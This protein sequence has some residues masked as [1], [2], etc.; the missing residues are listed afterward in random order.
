MSPSLVPTGS[1]NL[2]P[3]A[4]P[5]EPPPTA[6]PTPSPSSHSTLP[7]PSASNCV[8]SAITSSPSSPSSVFFCITYV[9]SGTLI[10]TVD[11]VPPVESAG[12]TILVAGVE[13]AIAE[14]LAVELPDVAVEVSCVDNLPI[15]SG[16]CRPPPPLRSLRSLRSLS[17]S[18]I[19][20][21]S[22]TATTTDTSGTLLTLVVAL[23]DAAIN[24]GGDVNADAVLEE[25]LERHR[26]ELVAA[27]EIT[28]EEA[29]EADGTV[30]VISVDVSEPEVVS[31][32]TAS[33]SPDPDTVH[34]NNGGSSN[35]GSSA[36][37][38]EAGV[39]D[40]EDDKEKRGERSGNNSWWMPWVMAAT[41]FLLGALVMRCWVFFTSWRGNRKGPQFATRSATTPRRLRRLS[42]FNFK[43]SPFQNKRPLAGRYASLPT[44]S[45]HKGEKGTEIT[46]SSSTA[47]NGA[48]AAATPRL[49]GLEDIAN[50]TD[51]QPNPAAFPRLLELRDITSGA[52]RVGKPN[53]AA[54]PRLL[55][56]KDL[57][58]DTAV[59]DAV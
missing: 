9:A 26:E 16:T 8:A 27:G 38:G 40:T 22:L 6:S 31:T 25:A 5:T 48:D 35:G 3:T 56:L 24:P 53:P 47:T 1:P 2:E 49:L 55:G 12:M 30:E 29:A 17:V 33:P 37:A 28:E 4:S 34:F 19:V 59:S 46:G 51:N 45:F 42:P 44:T 20:E 32:P 14:I 11:S 54:K 15:G 41:W 13:G 21:F 23:I 7:P 52:V 10:I 18:V 57:T 43:Y 39:L 36:A 58:I 50:G